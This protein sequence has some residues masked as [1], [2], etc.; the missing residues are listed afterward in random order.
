MSNSSGIAVSGGYAYIA[1]VGGVVSCPVNSNTGS[2]GTCSDAGSGVESPSVITINN[3][4]A[5]VANTNSLYIC[6]LS[7]NGQLGT[8]ISTSGMSSVAG[9]AFD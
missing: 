9:I 3:G 2:L 6:P 5:Y 1:N 8:C 7:G 4:Y